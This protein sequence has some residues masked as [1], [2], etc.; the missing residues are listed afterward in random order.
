MIL[1]RQ[2]YRCKTIIPQGNTYCDSCKAIVDKAKTERKK[3]TNAR[4]NKKYNKFNRNAE[5][6]RFYQSREWKALRAVKLSQCGYMCEDCKAKGLI[7]LAVDVHHIVEIADDWDK[8]LDIDN[9]RALCVSCH[10]NRHNRWQSNNNK[11]AKNENHN[12]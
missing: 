1:M 9:L 8:R 4:A 10:N 5:H 12:I 11:R 3:V 7:T 2:C 6:V